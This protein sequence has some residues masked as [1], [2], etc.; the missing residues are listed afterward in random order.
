MTW[1]FTS[2]TFT[3][4]STDT[5]LSEN[6]NLGTNVDNRIQLE[7]NPLHRTLHSSGKRFLINGDLSWDGETDTLLI[8]NYTNT[9]NDQNP[10]FIGSTGSLTLGSKTQ[11]EGKTRLSGGTHLIILNNDTTSNDEWGGGP[12]NYAGFAK[13]DGGSFICYGGTVISDETIVFGVA[14]N[15]QNTDTG[16]VILEGTKFIK[17]GTAIR[18]LRFDKRLQ[19]YYSSNSKIV[20][21]IVD[22]GFNVTH[23]ALPSIAQF[24]IQ[25]GALNQLANGPDAT[26]L[27]KLDVSNNTNFFDLGFDALNTNG[28]GGN[29]VAKKYT[30]NGS[31]TGSKIR[32]ITKTN[33]NGSNGGVRRAG[34]M[35]VTCSF[36][37]NSFDTSGNIISNAPKFLRDYNNGERKNLNG[38][39]DTADKTYTWSDDSVITVVTGIIN[40][41]LTD[42][43]TPFDQTNSLDMRGK[44]F[45]VT[46]Q[47]ANQSTLSADIISSD[48]IIS[49]L[50]NGDYF[51]LSDM[52]NAGNNGIWQCTE[53]YG[54][55][56]AGQINCTKTSNNPVNASSESATIS[57]HGLDLFDIE[58]TPK[59]YLPL[60]LVDAQLRGSYTP[61]DPLIINQTFVSDSSWSNSNGGLPLSLTSLSTWDEVYDCGKEWRETNKEYPKFGEIP[62]IADASQISVASSNMN[63]IITD[64]NQ[65]NA[66]EINTSTDTLTIEANTLGITA[67]SKFNGISVGTGEEITIQNG[68]NVNGSTF[69][70]TVRVSSLQDLSNVTING[71]LILDTAGT[72][73]FSNVVVT[74]DVTNSSTGALTIN[75]TNGSSL[76][77]S[78]AGT[79]NGQVNIQ[80]SVLVSITVVDSTGTPI[81]NARVYIE[82]STSSPLINSLTDINGEVSFNYNFSSD[83]NISGRVAKQSSSPYYKT[84]PISGTITS[85]GFTATINMVS[86]E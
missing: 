53:D 27:E 51:Q 14:N 31:V 36:K 22:G 68:C 19:S 8:Q 64:V 32:A 70:G 16:E 42:N 1:S 71:D 52:V 28:V 85:N 34:I 57:V 48:S 72:Y 50:K 80:N 58:Q 49:D 23:R 73:N 30:V 43:Q 75:A 76:T 47:V 69:G 10:I 7:T 56:T 63:V 9:T 15:S 82:D 33:V 29:N 65:T 59:Q 86:D 35:D 45:S 83:E 46:V 78:E 77:T 37:I 67:G 4:T 55:I 21:M 13:E 60:T 11:S 66:F 20:G 3:Q 62:L 24:S 26:T 79:G 41:D 84:S 12:S 61:S 6:V 81:Q 2:P 39:D 38:Q 17:K 18:E 44:N 5:D 25:N 40:R 54:E 74:G